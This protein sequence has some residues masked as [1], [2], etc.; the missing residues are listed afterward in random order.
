MRPIDRRA[1]I[2]GFPAAAALA[3]I[4]GGAMF[5]RSLREEVAACAARGCFDTRIGAQF[6]SAIGPFLGGTKFEDRLNI[7]DPPKEGFLNFYFAATQLPGRLSVIKCNC[8]FIGMETIICDSEFI[9]SFQRSINYTRGSFYGPD[10]GKIWEEEKSIFD[11][12]SARIGKVLLMWLIGHE[13]GHAVLHDTLNFERRRAMTEEEELQADKFFIERAF[14]HADKQQ[15]QDIEGAINQLI[16]SI[17]SIAFRPKPGGGTAVIAP[18]VDNVHPPWAIRAL[19]LGEHMTRLDSDA[20][21]D[22]QFYSSL[23]G[24]F[25]IEPGGTDI[26]SFCTATN[27]RETAARLQQERLKNP[28]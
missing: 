4:G 27:L 11:Q 12:A 21:K 7:T 17:F 9:R 6:K 25:D 14:L 5:H 18:S 1:I 3:I 19:K 28:H 8:A 22:N 2:G 24:H 15:R 26:G 10:T 20:P 13:I 23:A 16:F